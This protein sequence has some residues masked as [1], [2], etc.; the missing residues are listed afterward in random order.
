[1]SD[2]VKHECGIALLRLLKPLEYYHLKYGSWMYGLNKLYLLMEKQHNR[3]QD[4]AGLANIKLHHP[5]GAKYIFRERSNEREPIRK[6]FES[7]HKQF[8]TIS[9]RNTE[10]L[11]DPAWAKANLP[12]SGEIFLGHV[13]YG[14]FGKN[15]IETVHPVLRSNNWK[16]RSLVLAGNFNLTNVDELFDLLVDLG[17]HPRGYTD[18]VTVLE[19]V[20]HYLDTENQRLFEQYKKGGEANI[21]ISNHI[22]DQLDMGRILKSASKDWDG[23]YAM[24]GIT[25]SGDAFVVRDPWGIRPAYYY[26]DDE[27]AVVTSER[28]VIQ[29]SFNVKAEDVHE[30]QPGYAFIVKHHGEVRV[31]EI[32]K[33]FNKTACSFERIYFSRGSDQ[34]IYKER[35]S[36]GENL[37]PQIMQVIDNDLEN[38]VFSYI[39]NTAESAFYGMIKGVEDAMIATKKQIIKDS[40]HKL[41]DD[42]L[43]KLISQR[44]RV[45]KIAV[46]DVK[47]RTFISQDDGRNDLVAHVYDIT[48]G[49]VV[50]GKDNLVVIDDSIVRG[51]T[52]K[53]SIIRIL[54]RLSPQKIV[55]VSSAPQIRYPDCYGIDMTRLDDFIAFNAA[56]A[57]LKERNMGSIINEVYNKSKA[58]QHLPKEQIVN[59]V[60]EIYEPF[61]AQEVSDKIAELLTVPGIHAEVKIVYQSIE[62]LHK[63]CP[64]NKGDWYFT[65]N[66][67]TPGGN[68]VVNTSFINYI[69][70]K[71]SRA[72]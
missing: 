60:K 48:Y 33:P 6:V 66:Y 1:M 34:D 16:A 42:E 4:G 44:P 31:E 46:K 50:A 13:R 28:P 17:Q 72:Y 54:D 37:V 27:F 25:G 8:D 41:T 62:N 29:T 49:T 39:P 15:D 55:I 59:Y 70:G 18:T 67:P 57:L 30:L 2:Q 64:D 24:G 23:G 58:Q 61:T 21:D 5:P 69:E 65:G 35:K 68:K 32:R 26:Y 14:T 3:G 53:E 52:L 9:N 20:G 38:T 71:K 22:A 43:N 63:S 12:F 40:L 36:L 7:I 56:I 47:L 19:K 11:L 45:E 51:T 10:H